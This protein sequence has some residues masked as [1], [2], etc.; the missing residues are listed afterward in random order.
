MKPEIISYS[1]ITNNLVSLNGKII[2]I[3]SSSKDKKICPDDIYRHFNM[4]YLKFF[5]MDNLAKVGFLGAE[6][7]FNHLQFDRNNSKKDIAIVCFNRA[8]SLHDDTIYQNT[9]Q[10]IDNYYPSPSVFVYTLP[11][12]VTGEIAIRNKIEGETSF[13]VTEK[14]SPQLMCEAIENVFT[15]KTVNGLLCGWADYY[16]DNCDVLMMYLKRGHDKSVEKNSLITEI[17]SLYLD[18]KIQFL[19]PRLNEKMSNIHNK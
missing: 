13:Y 18:N 16:Q 6:L 10:D 15:D 12:I 8:S 17:E 5:K 3:E 4:Q 7:I 9:I 1:R 11:N 2:S 14:F 19:T